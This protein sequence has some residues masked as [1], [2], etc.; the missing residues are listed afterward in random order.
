MERREEIKVGP[1][2]QITLMNLEQVRIFNDAA[3]PVKLEGSL[4]VTGVGPTHPVGFKNVDQ[5]Q[6]LHR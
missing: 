4:F 1:G 5:P 6:D 3:V 2:K